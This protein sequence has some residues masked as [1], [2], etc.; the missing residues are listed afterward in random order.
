MS[1]ETLFTPSL[2][3]RVQNIRRSP[4]WAQAVHMYYAAEAVAECRM[5][6]RYVTGL[7]R[8]CVLNGTWS[9]FNLLENRDT[10][11]KNKQK[12]EVTKGRSSPDMQSI[13]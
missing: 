4:S 2:A 5:S 13:P 12:K 11:V 6:S 10:R 9:S 8:S 1:L 7:F 3:C